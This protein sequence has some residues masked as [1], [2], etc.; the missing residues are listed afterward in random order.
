MNQTGI[1][2]LDKQGVVWFY[3]R[4]G[5][6]GNLKIEGTQDYFVTIPSEEG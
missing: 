1:I 5:D 6:K 2:V 4:V 3:P